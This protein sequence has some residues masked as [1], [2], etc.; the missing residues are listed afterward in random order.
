[1][2]KDLDGLKKGE[3]QIA[4]VSYDSV[5]VLK[6]FGKKQKIRYPLLSDPKSKAIEAFGIRNK[7]AKGMMD[8]VP[9]PG[10]FIVDREGVIREKLFYEGYRKRHVGK[11]ILEATKKLPKPE[12]RAA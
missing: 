3:I 2:Q 6:E 11:D 1:M 4:A 7:D 10:T 12:K 5:D 8:G 9:H